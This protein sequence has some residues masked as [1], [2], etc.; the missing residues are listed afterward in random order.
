M[1][2][3]EILLQV[4]QCKDFRNNIPKTTIWSLIR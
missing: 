2:V 3:I 1:L 4:K